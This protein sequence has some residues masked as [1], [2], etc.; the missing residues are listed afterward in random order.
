MNKLTT[1]ARDLV[2]QVRLLLGTYDATV[3]NPR[4]NQKFRNISIKVLVVGGRQE[5]VRINSARVCENAC[6]QYYGV[7]IELT[8][9]PSKTLGL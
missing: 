1:D 9:K 6:N 5:K 3:Y 4:F 8:R 2:R 7:R